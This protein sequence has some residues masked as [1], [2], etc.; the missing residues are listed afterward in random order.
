LS[1]RVRLRAKLMA[2][3]ELR[4]TPAGVP[5][6]RAELKHAGAVAEAGVERQL[7]FELEA[8]AVGEAGQRLAS[9]ALGIEL[10]IDG[11]LAPRSKRSRSLM[12]HITE[13]KAI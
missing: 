5:V 13:F 2:R 7:D 1:N 11:F 4:W 12:L 10:E 9:Q 6:L 3:G 8:V